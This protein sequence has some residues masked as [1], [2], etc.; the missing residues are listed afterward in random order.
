MQLFPLMVIVTLIFYLQPQAIV[1]YPK[2]G[3]TA[4]SILMESVPDFFKPHAFGAWS[5]G[6]KGLAV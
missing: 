6:K 2:L 3:R 4:H 1:T 5:T